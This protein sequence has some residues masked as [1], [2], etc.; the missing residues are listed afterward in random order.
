VSAASQTKIFGIRV[1]L[2]PKYLVLGLIFVAALLFWYNSRTEESSGST[3]VTRPAPDTAGNA[4]PS[5]AVTPKAPR[6]TRT[7]SA[8]RGVLRLRPV[9]GARGDIDPTLR[10][11]LLARVQAVSLNAVGRSLFAIGPAP[12]AAASAAVHTVK[13]PVKPIPAVQPS[14]ISSAPPPPPAVN[15]PLRFYGFVRPSTQGVSNRGLFMDGDNVVVASEGETVNHRYLVVEL[16]PNSARMEDTQLKQGQ[17][18]PVVPE[19]MNR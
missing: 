19:A 15:I 7:S 4:A 6:R 12:E 13:I 3:G 11:D 10:L 1:G 2:D 14:E 9:N 17:T 18:L 5:L 8:D 16:T